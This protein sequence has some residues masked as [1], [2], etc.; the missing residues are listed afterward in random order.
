MWIADCLSKG[1]DGI[2]MMGCKFGDN[3]QC[4]FVKGSELANY[5]L[6]KLQETLDRLMLEADRVKL[7]Q[8][9]ISDYDR[10]PK[11]IDDFVER[12][13]EFEPNPYKDM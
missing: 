8:V 13:G 10:I 11:I 5:R 3:Y 6:T 4:H 1:I 7:E 2:L 9:A 12:L